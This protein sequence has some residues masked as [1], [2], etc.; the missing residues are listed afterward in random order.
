MVSAATGAEYHLVFSG[1][2]SIAG[3]SISGKEIYSVVASGA[4]NAAN[5]LGLMTALQI[6]FQPRIP[7]NSTQAGS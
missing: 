5:Q 4:A 7:S 6:F 3:S 2:T 1:V